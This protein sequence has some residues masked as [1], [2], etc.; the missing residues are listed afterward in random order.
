MSLASDKNNPTGAWKMALTS[1]KIRMQNLITLCGPERGRQRQLAMQLDFSEAQMSQLVRGHKKMG[2]RI[3]RRIEKT[4]G[5]PAGWMDV[6]H[7]DLTDED[8][9]FARRFHKLTATQ[10][11]ALRAFLDSFEK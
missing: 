3:A 11:K 6:E 5:L 10:K 9:A 7:N 8:V 2:A 4:L 1:D